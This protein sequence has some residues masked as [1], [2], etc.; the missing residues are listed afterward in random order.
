MPLLQKIGRDIAHLLYPQLCEGCRRPLLEQEKVLCLHCIQELPRTGYHH[1]ADNET[2]LR[3]A[4]RFPFRHATS[5]AY[6]T[7]DGLLQH[8]LHALKYKSRKDIG[9]FLGQQLGYDLL[10]AGMIPDLIVP[11]PLHK[12]KEAQRGYNQSYH[13]AEGIASIL[14]IEVDA[15]SLKRT[16]HTESQTQKTREERVE[17]VSDAFVCDAGIMGRYVLLCDDVL[18][19]G[20]TLEACAL[21]MLRVPGMQVSIATI[22]IAI[23]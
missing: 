7:T 20:A 8:L 13:I 16:R 6:F 11:V 14:N 21:A 1:I 2:A 4:G 15:R 17:N 23:D 22:G 19:T 18:T 10:D 3:F 12:K 9:Y 5:M